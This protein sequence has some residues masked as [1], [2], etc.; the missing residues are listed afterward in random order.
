MAE[1]AMVVL[2]VAL[3]LGMALIAWSLSAESGTAHTR[4]VG[5]RQEAYVIVRGRY[6]P[7]SITAWRGI[8]LRLTFV[9]QDEDPCSERVIFSGLGVD[10]YLPAHAATEVTLLPLRTGEFLFT[11]QMGMYQGTLVVKEPPRGL[12]VARH[13]QAADRRA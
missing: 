2:V 6:R 12:L 4:L 13:G 7:G 10:R 9:R 3:V 11:C 1:P 5:S 8:P